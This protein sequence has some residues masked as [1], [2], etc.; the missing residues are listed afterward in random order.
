M[1]PAATD[2]ELLELLRARIPREWLDTCL[3]TPDGQAMLG[4]AVAMFVAL[5]VRDAERMSGLF[6]GPHSLQVQK[7]ASG[8]RN[9]TTALAFTRRRAGAGL[10]LP[11]GTRVQTP[12]G[13]VFLTTDPVS[14]GAQETGVEKM[15]GGV[16]A[17]AGHFAEIPPDEITEFTP[18]ARGLT[19]A[20]TA[21]E[22]FAVPGGFALRLTTDAT[23]PHPWRASIVGLPFEV[24]TASGVGAVNVGKQGQIDRVTSGDSWFNDPDTETPYAWT[25]VTDEQFPTWAI[26]VF[27]FEWAIRDWNEVGFT[28]RNATPVVGGRD[29]TLDALVE[30]RGRPRRPG[31]LDEAVRTRLLRRPLSPSALGVLEQVVV[32]IAPHGF[33]RHDVRVYELGQVPAEADALAENFPKAGGSLLD[34]HATFVGTPLTP[35]EMAARAPDGSTLASFVNPGFQGKYPSTPWTI[36][37]DVMLPTGF[38]EPAAREIRLATWEAVQAARQRGCVAW[39]Y[40]P[41]QWGYPP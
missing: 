3:S 4:A 2:E 28:V 13:H 17:V 31:E 8:A 41:E 33:G 29:G 16:A 23:K 39:L 12:D 30:A 25:P 21:I 5:D 11:A 36:V 6:V 32:A 18:V 7:P 34:L 19:G 40:H 26:G 9:A 27:P 35:D 14:F 22:G 15:V 1:I 37:V 10:T 20:G 38:D 24:L